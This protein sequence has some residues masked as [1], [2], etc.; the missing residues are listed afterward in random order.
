MKSNMGRPKSTEPLSKNAEQS[1]ERHYQKGVVLTYL[2]KIPEKP[3]GYIV[4]SISGEIIK[5]T[6]D[7]GNVNVDTFVLQFGKSAPK[8]PT[9]E[10][11]I[12]P[13]TRTISKALS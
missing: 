10:D 11:Y 7:N 2:D 12:N 8:L 5:I 3:I 1:Y 13:H 4:D 6:D 9:Q